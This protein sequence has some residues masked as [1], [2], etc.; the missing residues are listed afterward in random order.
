MNQHWHFVGTELTEREASR[1]V[2]WVRNSG[3]EA[4][5]S[6]KANGKYSVMKRGD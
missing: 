3:K 4:K 5:M 2:T 6:K 1:L